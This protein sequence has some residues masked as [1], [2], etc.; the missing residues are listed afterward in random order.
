MVCLA[1]LRPFNVIQSQRLPPKRSKTKWYHY[2]QDISVMYF[3]TVLG[4]FRPNIP[5]SWSLH[6]SSFESLILFNHQQPPASPASA[7]AYDQRKALEHARSGI[8]FNQSAVF[9]TFASYIIF[10]PRATRLHLYSTHALIFGGKIIACPVH[11]Q[12]TGG[13]KLFINYNAFSFPCLF[14]FIFSSL[15]YNEHAVKGKKKHLVHRGG[16]RFFVIM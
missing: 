16:K 10:V 12:A 14:C 13:E 1:R 11:W 15:K 4:K 8:F 7:S 2:I 6:R 5:H 3:N 9:L